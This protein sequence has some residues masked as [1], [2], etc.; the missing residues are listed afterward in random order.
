MEPKFISGIAFMI[1]GV[2][3]YFFKDRII[4]YQNLFDDDTSQPVRKKK[5]EIIS[6]VLIVVGLILI[7]SN[8]SF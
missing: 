4:K 6:K 1:F 3:G 7:L 2:L 8:F 5:L